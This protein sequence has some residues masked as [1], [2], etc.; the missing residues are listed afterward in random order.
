MLDTQPRSLTELVPVEP[1]R[2]PNIVLVILDCVADWGVSEL[3]KR[4]GG[5]PWP[6]PLR[7]QFVSFPRSVSSASWTLPSHAS[8]FTGLPPWEHGVHGRSAWKLPE[9]VPTLADAL[10]PGG[11]ASACISA[12]GFLG[13]FSGLCRGFDE[14]HVGSWSEILQ[15]DPHRLRSPLSV[16]GDSEAK[17][18]GAV[19][20]KENAEFG[21]LLRRFLLRNPGLLNSS[22]RGVY[23][24]AYP[25]EPFD[26][27]VAS[28]VEPT[29]E[30]WLGSVKKERPVF[31]AINYLDAHEPYYREDALVRGRRARLRY[32][33]TSQDQTDYM[34]HPRAPGDPG[35]E[36]LRQLYLGR[37][38]YLVQRLGR[39]VDLLERAGRWDDT[40]LIVTADHG[41]AFGTAGA[42]FHGLSIDDTVLRVP[43]WVRFPGGRSAGRTSDVWTSSLDVSATIRGCGLAGT[44]TEGG[45]AM[46]PEDRAVC[47]V[48]DGVA[49]LATSA[50][51]PKATQE[52]LDH[53]LVAV[54]DGSVKLSY[55][56]CHD[57]VLTGTDG[58][59]SGS[60]RGECTDWARQVGK[61]MLGAKAPRADHLAAWG[62]E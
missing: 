10:R 23:K 44:G 51:F 7:G 15:R 55:D 12:N 13:P 8:L 49:E 14:T 2:R 58:N 60:A 35:V 42:M 43:L 37:V 36:I 34:V 6:S 5:L 22:A 45:T 24:L 33:W 50:R 53:V 41:Q 26:L 20:P 1:F 54:Y 62:Y 56:A 28:W 17:A 21:A 30:T 4:D 39:L 16:R 59:G 11:Y 32:A 27:T 9:S 61:K 3:E 19:D 25:R 29:L 31:V 46:R 47:G 40:L 48:S 38:R 52:R 57:R 18:Q